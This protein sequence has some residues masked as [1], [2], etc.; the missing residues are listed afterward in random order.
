MTADDA[1]PVQ[2]VQRITLGALCRRVRRARDLSRADVACLADLRR[3]AITRLERG[4]LPSEAHFE[5]YVAALA[6]ARAPRP[7]TDGQVEFLRRAFAAARAA[8]ERE[9]S[10]A[11][12][13]YRDMVDRRGPKELRDMGRRLA[14][15]P[16]PAL[17]R[18]E[19][20]FVHAI[21]AGTLGFCGYAVDDPRLRHW[22][23]WHVLGAYVHPRLP[24][25]GA[26]MADTVAQTSAHRLM[27]LALPMLFTAQMAALTD[28]LVALSPDAFGAW[29]RTA[30]TLLV[31]SPPASAGRGW[32]MDGEVVLVEP[33][34][35][36]TREV[37]LAP[38]HTA[39]FT[40][41]SWEPLDAGSA[42]RLAA[43]AA[44]ATA[45]PAASGLS[46][47]GRVLCAAHC[48]P[49]RRLHVNDWPEVA[50]ALS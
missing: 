14:S 31:S 50:A 43:A 9:A 32:Q 30:A 49:D 8:D 40:L 5:A 47:G 2:A 37:E 24:I 44:R 39:R 28:R 26:A 15:M 10:Y 11:W 25:G 46:F 19:L 35:T 29:W 12:V 27:E 34:R 13:T 22:A 6:D 48:D 16:Y 3:D 23:A 38:G 18:D 33:H 36:E 7:L 1:V 4:S 20:F 41:A 45:T 21:N 17:I 42:D